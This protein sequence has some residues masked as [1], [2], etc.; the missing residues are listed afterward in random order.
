MK[1][2]VPY[3]DDENAILARMYEDGEALHA[4]ADA[5]GRTRHSVESRIYKLGLKRK[6][7]KLAV[8]A[9]YRW[10]DAEVEVLKTNAAAPIWKLLELLPGRSRGAI[11]EQLAKLGGSVER[12]H[13]RPL[14]IPFTTA[15]GARAI[16]TE[17]HGVVPY[18]PSIHDRLVARHNG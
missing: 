16:R 14:N 11:Y 18:V 7:A 5:L 9:G 2:Y 6:R 4:I 15:S 3:D 17:R 13:S 8:R 1:F 10:T 12:E